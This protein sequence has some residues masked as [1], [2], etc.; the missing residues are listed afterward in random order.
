MPNPMCKIASIL[1]LFLASLCNVTA[2]AQDSTQA[3]V[4]PKYIDKVSSKAASLQT[5]LDRATEKIL[6]RMQK[7]EEKMKRKLQKLDSLAAKNIFANAD[8]K[9]KELEQRLK[10]NL[11]GP[12]IASL[13]TMVNSIKFL[14]QNAAL[15]SQA[16]EVKEKL[17][18]TLT[19]V[20]SL[21]DQFS[22]AEEIKKFLKERKQFL[23]EKLAGL[24]F[25][26]ELKKL[27]K[28]VFYYSQQL[29]ELKSVIKDSKKAE[30]KAIELLSKTRQFKDFMRKHSALAG[31]FRMPGTPDD[32]S[33][34]NL[35]G[36]QTRSMVN[37]LIQQQIAA[38]GP[39]AQQIFSQ[40]L[41]AAQNQLQQLKNKVRQFGGGSSDAEMPDGFR[42]NNQR[43]KNFWKKWELG[44]NAQNNRANGV[45]PNSSDLGI[46][47]GFRP[48]NNFIA[49]VGLAGRI[50][51]G[52][53][54]RHLS[55]S[56]S[57]ISARS[58]AELKI[59]GSF[60]A[61][62]G[63]EMNY[64]PEIRDVELLK[65]YSAWQKACLAGISKTVS[66]KSK[67]FKKTKLSLLFDALS[68]RQIPKTQPI[69]FRIG[70]E[71]R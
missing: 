41:A 25:A 37:G 55:I 48:H 33:Q 11:S 39:G 8:E 69:V 42:E 35:S 65:D 56:Y 61:V 23:K 40:N 53:D 10:G 22:K 32:P 49:G 1:I 59:K 5:K 26:K 3:K 16:K 6:A 62:A 67:F 45:M 52:K 7:R 31:L 50:G 21:K 43:K 17:N 24:G 15:I 47:A 66:L 29:A 18:A 70:Y 44:V 71:W 57:G 46:S 12:Y 14:N 20:N 51:W 54:I 27:N 9:Y 68:Y 34:V 63:F 4:S 64:R 2:H 19:K 30:R 28:D 58:F 13:D 38:G 60:H 36:L